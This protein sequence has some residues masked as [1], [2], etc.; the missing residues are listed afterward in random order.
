MTALPSDALAAAGVRSVHFA[1]L[2]LEPTV[3]GC[4]VLPPA[5]VEL[6]PAAGLPLLVGVLPLP[7]DGLPLPVDPHPAIRV[8]TQKTGARAAR[9]IGVR[10]FTRCPP[11]GSASPSSSSRQVRDRRS[12]ADFTPRLRTPSS[13]EGRQ[14]RQVE[15]ALRIGYLTTG[16]RLP[17]VRDVVASL[18]IKPEHRRKCIRRALQSRPPLV[19][20]DWLID[21]A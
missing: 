14:A 3:A 6:P 15:H 9:R 7:V 10:V 1:P 17:K 2:P 18:A 11:K 4:D 5:G 21:P 13:K 8:A 16:G 12:I 20:L 19:F